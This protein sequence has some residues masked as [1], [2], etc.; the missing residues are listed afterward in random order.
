M[1]SYVLLLLLLLDGTFFVCLFVFSSFFVQ[2]D[3]SSLIYV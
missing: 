1:I 3:H 2:H